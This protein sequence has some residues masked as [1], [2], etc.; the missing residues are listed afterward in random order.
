[1]SSASASLPASAPA[2]A[3][4]DSSVQ[5]ALRTPHSAILWGVR[6]LV[7]DD[8]EDSRLFVST[9][10]K[11]QGAQVTL[12]SSSAE[13][14]ERLR[15][16]PPDVLVSDIGMPGEDGFELM[17]RIRALDESEGGRTP[18]AALTAYARP[19]DREQALASGYQLHIAKPADPA[20]LA[21]LVAGL[22]GRR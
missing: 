18:A 14:F 16:T 17:R 5:S 21:R 9:A 3:A 7:V 1:M 22:V 12:A 6:G 15:R 13:A 4:E 19:E 20:E 11:A 10:L 2:E 8:D